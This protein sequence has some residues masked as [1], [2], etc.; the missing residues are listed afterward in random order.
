MVQQNCPGHG[1][2]PVEFFKQKTGDRKVW[3]WKLTLH[4]PPIQYSL[5]VPRDWERNDR[6]AFDNYQWE[7]LSPVFGEGQPFRFQ[8]HSQIVLPYLEV[9]KRAQ[10]SGFFGEVYKVKIHHAHINVPELAG[11]VRNDSVEI[12]LKKANEN[13]ELA[14]FFDK[15]A[16]NLTA[17]EHRDDRCLLFPWADGGNL[18]EFWDRYKG[19]RLLKENIKWVTHQL[20]GLFSALEELNNGNCRH[21]DLKP[22]N[23]LLFNDKDGKI[24]QIADLGLA[25][26][27]AKGAT[28]GFRR[29]ANWQT[30][31]PPGTSRYEPPEMDMDRETT[32]SVWGPRSRAYDIWSMGCVVLEMLMWLSYGLKKVDEFRAK[33]PYFWQKVGERYQIQSLAQEH[34]DKMSKKWPRGSICGDL[35]HFV[36]T[37]LL[38]V[39]MPS[40]KHSSSRCRATAPQAHKQMRGIQKRYYDTTGDHGLA[41]ERERYAYRSIKASLPPNEDNLEEFDGLVGIQRK[42]TEERWEDSPSTPTLIKASQADIKHEEYVSIHLVMMW[43]YVNAAIVVLPRADTYAK[44]PTFPQEDKL[45]FLDFLNRI[46]KSNSRSSNSGYIA[47]IQ[48]T[49]HV[50]AMT[51][52]LPRRCRPGSRYV[53]LSHCWGQLQEHERFCLYQKNHSQLEARI[54]FDRLPKTFRDAITVT[55]GLGIEYIWID[56]LCIIQDDEDDWGTESSKMETVFS[57][58]YCT[59]SAAS[60]ESSLEGFLAPRPPRP[61]VRLR[62]EDSRDLYV[63]PHIDDFHQDVELAKINRRGWVLQE[64]ALSRRSIYY[65]RNQVYWECGEGIRCETMGRLYNSKA[66]FL[67]DASF[68]RSALE[69]YRDGRQ[70]LIQDLYERY[71]ALAFTKASDRAVAILGLQERL[72]RAFE[73]QAA[74]GTFESYF[75]RSI[76]WRRDE[77]LAEMTPIAQPAGRRVPSWSWFSKGGRIQYMNLTFEKTEW[78]HDDFESPFARQPDNTLSGQSSKSVSSDTGS[79]LRG[80]ARRMEMGEEALASQV[81][82]DMKNVREAKDFLAVQ[83]GRDKD[84]RDSPNIGKVHVLVICK[85]SSDPRGI[86]YERVG[87]ASLLPEQVPDEGIWVDIH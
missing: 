35:L 5:P 15:E 57:A 24:L 78:M 43:R 79:I 56:T 51:G 45:A 19:D 82:F 49:M 46:V 75:A 26:F 54:D 47:A 7:F 69:Y 44:D 59:L 37:G 27:H 18:Y 65:S 58:A 87:V 20:T 81:V 6:Y 28:T 55:R 70:L 23:I 86:K 40:D 77:Q 30:L 63:C 21:G 52:K 42:A 12:A 1:F 10:S 72:A 67:G 64:R 60:A 50:V 34:I 41:P 48:H 4:D 33:T 80:L 84:E 13:P 8:F 74:H 62:T 16:T 29:A 31:T 32:M 39:K 11:K 53:A 71:S 83:I 38:V 68:P 2:L 76:L 14:D 85:S 3:H 36:E 9:S 73:T 17:Y 22:E 25:A 61:C 66:A